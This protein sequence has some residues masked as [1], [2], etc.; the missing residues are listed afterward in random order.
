MNQVLD[1]FK[2]L[3]EMTMSKQFDDVLETRTLFG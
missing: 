1:S 3:I 2:Y